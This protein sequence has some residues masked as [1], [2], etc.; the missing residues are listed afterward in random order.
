MN[1]TQHPEAEWL[2]QVWK[3]YWS[4]GQTNYDTGINAMPEG[5]KSQILAKLKSAEIEGHIHAGK[6][7]A[8]ILKA[9]NEASGGKPGEIPDYAIRQV[10][11]HIER[12]E[13][14]LA[15]LKTI[16]GEEKTL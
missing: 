11:V 12:N 2:D 4:K 9:F 3:N 13:A 1:T 14:K 6:T 5:L 8:H 15:Q 7:I 10:E 16:K